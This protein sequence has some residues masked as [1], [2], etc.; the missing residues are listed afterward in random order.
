MN[1][2]GAPQLLHRNAV[3]GVGIIKFA[4]TFP[5]YMIADVHIHP[6]FTPA[7]FRFKPSEVVDLAVV[8]LSTKVAITDGMP[9]EVVL[10]NPVFG[11]KLMWKYGD[12][13]EVQGWGVT[14]RPNGPADI[15]FSTE[16]QNLRVPLKDP[17]TCEIR[18]E[19]LNPGQFND[20]NRVKY[21]CGGM[22][23][24]SSSAC[25]GDGGAP[26]V[27]KHEK[28][29]YQIGVFS[30][31][32]PHGLCGSAGVELDW[33]GY[34]RDNHQRFVNVEYHGAWIQGRTFQILPDRYYEA[35]PEP[36]VE[37]PP[38]VKEV[39]KRCG[40]TKACGNIGV[41]FNCWCDSACESAGD[42]CDDFASRCPKE[43][44][45]LE[46]S[47]SGHG[48]C[49][50]KNDGCWCSRDCLQVGD[51]CSDYTHYCGMTEGGGEQSCVGRCGSK[52]V[53]CFC[54]YKCVENNDCCIDYNV[55]LLESND[56][57]AG[58]CHAMCGKRSGI[59]W[60][61]AGCIKQGYVASPLAR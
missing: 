50:Y 32:A 42:C 12:E 47:C 26:M 6:S 34:K 52:A 2:S 31:L 21:I 1:I 4:E 14:A 15:E 29:S 3:A 40:S 39:P 41:N 59:C 24:S 38:R 55:C 54:D 17:T 27:F 8:K 16:L 44:P 48:Q 18:P 56:N 51:C 37:S 20:F 58:S 11:Q 23:G 19:F 35:P 33:Y 36:P 13:G 7:N 45:T 9:I 61:D 25:Y 5:K 22:K 60:C 28:K 46:G 53:G 49:G 57:G 10:A 43:V 30:G